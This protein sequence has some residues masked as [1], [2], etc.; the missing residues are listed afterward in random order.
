MLLF[1][2]TLPKRFL[3]KIVNSVLKK[4]Y[5]YNLKVVAN[6]ANLESLS[7]RE[8]A[9]III[10]YLVIS[11]LKLKFGYIKFDFSD[12]GAIISLD[13]SNVDYQGLSLNKLFNSLEAILSLS[14]L[15]KLD[16]SNNHLKALPEILNTANQ[17]E[18]LDLSFNNIYRIPNT[19]N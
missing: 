7:N 1:F 16:L 11:S 14:S 13:L 3:L 19:I 4:K 10:N 12:E 2:T 17:L 9:E 15:G 5:K 6:N 8:I 18:E